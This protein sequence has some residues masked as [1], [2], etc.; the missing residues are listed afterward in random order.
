MKNYIKKILG[1]D[2]IEE[3]AAQLEQMTKDLAVRTE[4]AEERANEA[5][6]K[7]VEAEQ[8]AS[9]AEQKASEA[10]QKVV[11]VEEKLAEKQKTAKEIATERKEPWVA[12]LETHV[13]KDNVRNGFFELDWNE[14]FVLQLRSAGYVGTTD[15]DI[16]DQWFNELCRNVGG[17]EGI[18]MS[19]RGAGY[20]N[21]ALRDD[22]RTEV[23]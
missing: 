15:E 2:K 9:E 19:R 10:E 1:L 16:V 8:K 13:G 7:I 6:K 20:V 17:E 23:S 3:Q 12:V 14:Y 4:E 18:D 21:R 22:G 11:E 5:E